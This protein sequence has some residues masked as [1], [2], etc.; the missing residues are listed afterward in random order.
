[1]RARRSGAP[2]SPN[3][4]DYEPLTCEEVRSQ[5]LATVPSVASELTWDV[6][7]DG[8]RYLVSVSGTVMDGTPTFGELHD[9]MAK[10]IEKLTRDGLTTFRSARGVPQ[11]LLSPRGAPARTWTIERGTAE[12][13]EFGSWLLE[14][15][16]PARALTDRHGEGALRRSLRS[17]GVS[18]SFRWDGA[19]RTATLRPA[20][21]RRPSPPESLLVRAH[22]LLHES[23]T[24]PLSAFQ[25]HRHVARAMGLT[26]VLLGAQQLL[27]W[28]VPTRWYTVTGAA[29][30]ALAT[31]AFVARRA[32]LVARTR[33]ATGL[34]LTLLGVVHLFGLLYAALCVVDRGRFYQL[35]DPVGDPPMLGEWFFTSVGIAVS[36]GTNDVHL[37]GL[38]RSLA[39]L[40]LL[41]V[42]GGAAAVVGVAVRRLLTDRDDVPWGPPPAHGDD[43]RDA[44]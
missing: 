8:S 23:L 20:A 34:G 42:F 29:I 27:A 22:D 3:P 18:V 36:E 44:R 12:V 39:H 40:E 33:L 9:D 26:A 16:F 32:G 6:R 28:S 25:R 35:Q 5:I 7:P 30:V 19:V 11:Q 13:V 43:L 1:M 37:R 41:L 21:N 17:A 15:A 31:V 2:D 14:A 24:A 38:A 4:S 10:T